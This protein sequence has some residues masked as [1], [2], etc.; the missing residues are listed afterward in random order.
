MMNLHEDADAFLALIN[1]VSE[2]TGIAGDIL[3]K[4]YYA[5]LMLYELSQKQNELKAYFKGGTALYKALKSI[6]RFSE[7]IDLTVDVSDCS[8][9]SQQKKRLEQAAKKYSV[10][11]R[12]TDPTRKKQEIDQRGTITS[13]YDY[14]PITNVRPEDRLQRFGCVKI[15]AT[16]FGVSEPFDDIEIESIVS[17]HAN[18]DQ[19]HVLRTRYDTHS[20][21]IKT[22]TL[23]RIFADKIFAAE[24]CLRHELYFDSA[25]HIYDLAVLFRQEQIL[26]F[27]ANQKEFLRIIKLKRKEEAAWRGSDLSN[28]PFNEFMLSGKISE[29]INLKEAF[30]SMQ[31][32]Y[33]FNQKDRLDFDDVSNCINMLFGILVSLVG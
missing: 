33:I 1:Y 13:I 16:S 25:K 4:D 23:E 32:I 28:R 12:T 20:F 14:V 17:Q 26:L 15:E 10:L 5:T 22:I 30:E 11:P 18:D 2:I 24:L 27:V 8:N 9:P 19:K 31:E 6:R 29:N 3:E 21:K 7:D